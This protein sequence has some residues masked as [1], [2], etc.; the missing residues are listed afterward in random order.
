MR[1]I[2]LSRRGTHS[3]RKEQPSAPSRVGWVGNLLRLLR[4]WSQGALPWPSLNTWRDNA[5][6]K[7]AFFEGTGAV[8]PKPI[9]KSPEAL[10]SWDVPVYASTLLSR[11]TERKLDLWTTRLWRCCLWRYPVRPWIEPWEKKSDE[12]I[13]KYG[14]LRLVLE[15]RYPGYDVEQC[16][17][18]I[19]VTLIVTLIL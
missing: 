14:P 11:Q 17:T 5:V 15:T 9:H 3:T 4:T 6:L 12:K 2:S 19:D 18:I 8:V 10:A 7:V 1:S 13:T 16:N